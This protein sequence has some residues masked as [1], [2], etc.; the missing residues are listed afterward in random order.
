MANYKN[1]YRYSRGSYTPKKS[2][3]N[4][5]SGSG[6]LKTL[7]VVLLVFLVVGLIGSIFSRPAGSA[8]PDTTKPSATESPTEAPTENPY[9]GLPSF[10]LSTW[11]EGDGS[12]A[13]VHT[14][15]FE[16]GMTWQQWVD[17][18]YNTAGISCTES[19]VEAVA[20]SG[21]VTYSVYGVKPTDLIVEGSNYGA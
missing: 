19:S 1:N 9:A 13:V 15:Y 7:G 17:S 21:G 8:E 2:N 20:N 16:E 18:E 10:K 5:S 4:K 12:V 11:I 14:F 6:F 3:D